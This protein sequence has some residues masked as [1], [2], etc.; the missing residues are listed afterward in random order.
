MQMGEKEDLLIT[1][2]YLA[3]VLVWLG[4]ALSKLIP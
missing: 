4:F 3:P 2:A 1:F